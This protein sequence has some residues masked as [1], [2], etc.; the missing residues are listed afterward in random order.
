MITKKVD[1]D[2]A[3]KQ[4]AEFYGLS[5]D[6]KATCDDPHNADIFYEMDTQAVYMYDQDSGNWLP[7]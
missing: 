4:H 6:D 2:D 7:Q 5:T 3:G 1:R